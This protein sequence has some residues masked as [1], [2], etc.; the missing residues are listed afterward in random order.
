DLQTAG[1][2]ISSIDVLLIFPAWGTGNGAVYQVDNIEITSPLA[3]SP[4]LEIFADEENASWPFWDCCGSTTPEVVTDEDSAYGAAVEF[5]VVGE[6]VLGFNSRSEFTETPAPFD[7]SGLM[8]DGVLQFDLKVITPTADPSTDWKMKIES[9][10]AAEAVELSLTQSTE[11][12]APSEQWQSYTYN[13]SDLVQAGLDAS[14]IDVLMVFPAWGA[15]DGTVYRLDNVRIYDP[16]AVKE[17]KGDVLFKN[18][19]L[20]AWPLWDCCG[21]STPTIEADDIDHGAVA[22]F[23]VSGDTVLGFNSRSEFTDTPEPIDAS[24]I[25]TDGVLQ[26]EM[27]VTTMT[28]DPATDWKMKIE[29]NGAA[30]AVELSLA[31]SQEGAAPA[32]NVWQTYTYSLQ[33]LSTAGLDISAIDVVMVFPAWGAGDGAVYRLDN[34]MIYDPNSV[35]SRKGIALFENGQSD[36]AL[37]DC[38]GSS[39]PTV[40][41][42]DS[43][44]GTVVEFTVSGDTVLGF[45]T[46]GE[47]SDNPSP[48]DASALLADGYLRFEMKVLTMPA[49][50]ATDWKMKIESNGAAEAV[51]LSLSASQEGAAPALD[52]WQTYTYSLQDLSTAGLD[53]SAIDVVMVFPAWGAGDGAVYRIDNVVISAP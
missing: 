12:A 43:T 40:E 10:G 7:A 21:S 29:S 44:H 26:F 38:C 16:T 17:F 51:E 9:N 39:T 5:T 47:F 22:E 28:A 25:L 27:K 34:V 35:P 4:S 11:G 20:D 8:A 53:I 3:G 2:D 24:A 13:I 48:Y 52:G 14:A 30:E 15:G 42:D 41:V 1:L 45:N 23:T 46:R 49:D 50:P 36:W 32:L 18:G 19:T 37:W 6:T 33:E 31:Q